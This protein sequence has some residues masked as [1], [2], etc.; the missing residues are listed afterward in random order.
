MLALALGGFCLLLDQGYSY[1]EGLAG[2]GGGAAPALTLPPPSTRSCT[3][4]PQA[5][6]CLRAQL[7]PPAFPVELVAEGWGP[8]A[9]LQPP[10]DFLMSGAAAARPIC[11]Q[12]RAGRSHHSPGERLPYR[13]ALGRDGELTSAGSCCMEGNSH[14]PLPG[15]K[16]LVDS[17]DKKLQDVP[18]PFGKVVFLGWPS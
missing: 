2:G 5:P 12:G 11:L 3:S 13:A 6:P 7:T 16:I 9:L 17:P 10:G 1:Q 18:L 8:G 4:G 15:S 14:C